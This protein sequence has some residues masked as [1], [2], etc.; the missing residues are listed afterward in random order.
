MSCPPGRCCR[1]QVVPEA[2]LSPV[3]PHSNTERNGYLPSLDGWRAIA[4]S[5]VITDHAFNSYL[6]GVGSMRWCNALMVGQT[7]VNLFFGISGY[8]ITSRLLRERD[9]SG[10]ISLPAFYARRAFRILPAALVYLAA[11]TVLAAFGFI[12][13]SIPELY[14]SLFFFRNYLGSEAGFYTGHFWSLS[15]EEHFYLLWPTLLVALA[16]L[17]PRRAALTALLLAGTVAAWR[18]VALL[19]SLSI[20]GGLDTNFFMR[21]DV[22]LDALLLGA[23]VALASRETKFRQFV[24]SRGPAVWCG[25]GAIYL[26]IVAH[27]GLRP[28]IW[29]GALVPVLLAGTVTHPGWAISR[30]LEQSVLRWVGRISYSLYVWQQFFFPPWTI[31]APLHWLQRWPLAV[32]ATFVFAAASYYLVERPMLRIG[33]RLAGRLE[34]RGAK[35]AATAVAAV[36]DRA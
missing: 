11:I 34:H 10:A 22:R 21:T 20:H 16:M 2:L 6:C 28:T 14:G 24:Q 33:Y 32:P 26:A 15:I 1:P 35:R 36:R 27:F 8:L 4:I 3:A 23:T 30:L 12:L 29:E 19:H 7:G 17:A 18:Q 5:L 31:A 25:L 13:V 9:A